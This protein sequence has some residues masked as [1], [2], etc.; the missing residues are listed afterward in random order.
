MV[1]RDFEGSRE[2]VSKAVKALTAKYP[3]YE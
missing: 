2:E 1:A 3:L